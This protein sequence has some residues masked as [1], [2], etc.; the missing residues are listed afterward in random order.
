V[1]CRGNIL[2]ANIPF[3]TDY[4]HDDPG[5]RMKFQDVELLRTNEKISEDAKESIR[6]RNAER[7]VG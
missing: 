7:L 3:A 5:G 1:N 2:G 6:R 4:P